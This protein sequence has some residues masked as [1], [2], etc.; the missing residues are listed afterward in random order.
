[1]RERGRAGA[2]GGVTLAFL[3]GPARSP[4][5]LLLRDF[6]SLPGFSTG[7]VSP[8]IGRYSPVQEMLDI[9]Q[10]SR[11]ASA[12]YRPVAPAVPGLSV[13]RESGV[14]RIVGWDALRRRAADVP[15]DVV[16]GLL[17]RTLID[18]GQPVTYVTYGGAGNL[19]AIAAAAARCGVV[20]GV[21]PGPQAT[22][23]ERAVGAAGGPG[24]TIV[25]LP[26][27][28]YGLGVARA[29]T[30]AEPGRMLIVM[31][32]PPEPARNR[33]LP[34]AVYGLGGDGGLKS[35]TTRRGGLVAATDV[36]AT[37]LQRLGV[38]RPSAMDGRPIE[39]APRKDAERLQ[40]MAN[41]LAIIQPRRESFGVNS[42]AMLALVLLGVLLLARLTGQL[43]AQSRLA[44]RL[45]ALAML[46]LPSLLLVTA[47]LRP[48]APAE[49]NLTVAGALL[50]GLGTDRAL[51]WPRAP[52]VPVAIMLVA[53]AWD[54]ALGGSNLTGQSLLG[55]NPFYGARFFGAGNE[56]EV[57]FVVATLIGVGSLL[58]WWRAARPAVV[59]GLAGLA[60]AMFLG[61]GK[62][63]ADV[64]GVIM[65][66]A[67]FGVAVL[68]AARRRLT[69]RNALLIVALPAVVLG[70]IVVIDHFTG[71]QSHLTR[72]V[73]KAD[74]PG[75][76]V[77]VVVRRF[78]ASV[79]GAL[80]DRVWVLVLVAL[81][82]LAWGWVRR[83][84]VL[85]P[86]GADNDDRNRSLESALLGGLVATLAGALANDSGP[87]ILLIGTVYLGVGVLYARGRP[88]RDRSRRPALGDAGEPAHAGGPAVNL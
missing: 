16:P 10:G 68:H 43:E 48:T 55:S 63:G 18:A 46:W 79:N 19:A 15:G 35:P 73:L 26:A 67:G 70:V 51:R 20:Q 11:V 29:I 40:S 74:N 72:T 82:L 71:G 1:M 62:L 7:L 75:E 78:S 66:A 33:L 60:L 41:R 53:Y 34:I 44:M 32:A 42:V 81:A 24:L 38:P 28:G 54:F 30:R 45:V 25:N 83:D 87:A 27:G 2:A 80:V 36:A 14:G 3:P 50:L 88:L 49:L 56:L 77:D 31:Q 47:A 86:L 84:R 57:T 85:A 21:S 9:S 58:C 64:G 12:L 5:P 17:A 39:P 23:R 76:L 59:F 69:W 65:V 13:D 4:Q 37:I 61:T 8:T 22:L 52:V 6:E